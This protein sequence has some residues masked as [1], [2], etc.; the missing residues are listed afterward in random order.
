MSDVWNL[1]QQLEGNTLYTRKQRK[2]FKVVR[3]LDDRVEFV[4]ENG[5]GT[6]RPCIREDIEHIVSLNLKPEALT[7]SHIQQELPSTRN[8]SYVAAIVYE[9]LYGSSVKG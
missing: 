3:V 1:V 8:S 9:V 5:N 4:P 6:R 2:R 7:P